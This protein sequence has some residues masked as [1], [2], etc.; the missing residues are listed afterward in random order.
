MNTK[1]KSFIEMNKDS[2]VYRGAW[3][4]PKMDTLKL[5]LENGCSFSLSGEE[6]EYL[7]ASLMYF[8]MCGLFESIN[9]VHFLNSL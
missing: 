9:G 5:D 1:L 6:V 3:N 2:N 8:K 4:H 7:P